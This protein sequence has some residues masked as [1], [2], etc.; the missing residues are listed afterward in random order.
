MRVWLLL[1]LLIVTGQATAHGGGLDAQGCHNDRKR[2]DYHCHRGNALPTQNLAP[3][4][5]RRHPQPP[6]TASTPLAATAAS[7]S[8]V[9]YA[10]CTAVRA[11]R[12]A[13]I[14]YGDPGYARQLDRDGDGVG[15]E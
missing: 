3:V 5:P 11:A 2:G 6:P 14:R 1:S 4:T 9:Y 10:N 13:P 8:P 15:C 12:A 7:A